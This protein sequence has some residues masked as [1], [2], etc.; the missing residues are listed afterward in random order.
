ME[1]ADRCQGL[2]L[3]PRA[4]TATPLGT[5]ASPSAEILVSF[6]EEDPLASG[7]SPIAIAIDD[8]GSNASSTAA[9]PSAEIL[10]S[11]EEEEPLASGRSPIAIPIDDVGSNASSKTSHMMDGF[12][13]KRSAFGPMRVKNN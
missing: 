2:R 10:V 13:E 12:K 6:E 9:S 3:S 4:E 7:R 5:A 1:G 8:V 11:F